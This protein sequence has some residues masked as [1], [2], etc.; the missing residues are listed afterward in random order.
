MESVWRLKALI[1]LCALS[2]T[3]QKNGAHQKMG[4]IFIDDN[5]PKCCVTFGKVIIRE[6]I[7]HLLMGTVFWSV[8]KSSRRLKA[9]ILLCALSLT[10][11]KHGAHQKMGYIFIDDN[12][13]KCCVTFGKVIIY[14]Y[15]AHL[16]MGAVFGASGEVRGV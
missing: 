11:Q 9:L 13:P 2:L 10:P 3:P 4:Y 1:L 15:I 8:R 14:E 6:Y 16:L 7:A 12:F 5:F